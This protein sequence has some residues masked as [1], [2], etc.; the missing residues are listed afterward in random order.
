MERLPEF[1]LHGLIGAVLAALL[2]FFASWW[3]CG[4][5]LWVIGVAAGGGFVLCGFVGERAVVWLL[6]AFWWV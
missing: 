2:A 6:E 5:E 3:A 1:M 4:V